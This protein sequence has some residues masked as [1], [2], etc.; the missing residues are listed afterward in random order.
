[1]ITISRS[2]DQLT[3]QRLSRP[4]INTY[5]DHVMKS[6]LLAVACLI[7]MV[8]CGGPPPPPPPPGVVYVRSAPPSEVVE[9]VPAQPSAEH[10]WIRGHYRWDGVAAAYVWVPGHWQQRPAG[11]KR[12]V[13][14]HW[15][16]RNGAWYWVEGHWRA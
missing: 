6:K 4:Y 3:S 7:G 2:G 15:Y 11:Y 1:M 5:E 14:G 13:P 12:W 8:G 10:V 9:V 16:E